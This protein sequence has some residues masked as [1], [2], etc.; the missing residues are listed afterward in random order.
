[1]NLLTINVEHK[2]VN[3]TSQVAKSKAA[4]E[5]AQAK[6]EDPLPLR[7]AKITQEAAL[8]KV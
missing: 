7:K 5:L 1:M 6:Q 2:S 4:A 8:K 3:G